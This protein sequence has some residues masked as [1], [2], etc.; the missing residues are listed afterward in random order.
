MILNLDLNPYINKIS[1]VDKINLGVDLKSNSSD[2]TPGGNIV[3]SRLLSAFGEDSIVTGFL[4]GLNGER[5]HTMLLNEGLVHDFVQ[6]QDE[7]KV[8]VHMRD[9]E[10]NYIKLIDEEPKITRED[11]KKI[12][13]LYKG[14][15]GNSEIICGSS[16]ILPLG[17]TDTI[18]FQ[19]VSIANQNRKRF[20]LAAR[21]EE[22]RKGIEAGPYMVIID[23]AMLEDL[24]NLYLEDESE[25]IKASNYILHRDVEFLV[26]C[27]PNFELMILGQEIGFRMTSNIEVDDYL[28]NDLRR[29]SAGFALGISR[30]YDLDMTLRLA[31]AFNRYDTD[32]NRNHIDLA[33]IKK[34]MGEVEIIQINYI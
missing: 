9:L 13:N 34:I 10:D 25:I 26:I 11:L 28:E 17:L 21:G 29:I 19:L 30:N 27:L 2:Y 22:L 3:I 7:T 1:N 31:Y 6:I 23:K 15:I 12:L 16:D 14:L 8:K 33:E 20:I 18:Y 4:G 5:Y 32:D 24:T